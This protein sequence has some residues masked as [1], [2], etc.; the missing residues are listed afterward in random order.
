MRFALD[1]FR[2]FF[3]RIRV[4]KGLIW[5]FVARLRRRRDGTRL[6]RAR[7]AHW[8]EGVAGTLTSR[9]PDDHDAFSSPASDLHDC[10]RWVGAPG[11]GKYRRTGDEDIGDR[12]TGQ[13]R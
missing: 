8:P 13:A 11:R 12:V 7:Q 10:Q 2:E 4:W 6:H 3:I 1:Q 9:S 5:D